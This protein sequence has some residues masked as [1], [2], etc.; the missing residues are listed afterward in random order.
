MPQITDATIFPLNKY[1]ST[2]RTRRAEEVYRSRIC[3]TCYC[4][5]IA[6]INHIPNKTCCMLPR[7]FRTD[8]PKKLRDF[9]P[10]NSYN[11]CLALAMT[12]AHMETKAC[13]LM[14]VLAT[15]AREHRLLRHVNG[16]TLRQA[17]LYLSLSTC[18]CR[19]FSSFLLWFGL[20]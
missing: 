6:T 15:K 5:I 2:R 19:F 11:V 10:H 13:W 1:E 14:F 18:D 3:T 12:V 8:S 16:R 17:Y 20:V 9:S 4:Y 7:H